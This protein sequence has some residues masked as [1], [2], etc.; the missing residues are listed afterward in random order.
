MLAR[1]ASMAGAGLTFF[2]VVSCCVL[3][4]FSCTSRSLL[5]VAFGLL[6]IV[7][8]SSLDLDLSTE[9]FVYLDFVRLIVSGL[10]EFFEVPGYIC[11]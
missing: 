9:P 4:S 11:C 1:H 7:T 10:L 8:L 2:T 6:L 3:T 5:T